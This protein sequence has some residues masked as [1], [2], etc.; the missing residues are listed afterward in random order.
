MNRDFE[1][2]DLDLGA[3]GRFVALASGRGPLLLVL[4]GFPDSPHGM[5]PLVERAAARGFRAVAP[6]LRGYAPSTGEGPFDVDTLAADVLAIAEHLAPGEPFDLVGHDWGAVISYALLSR[7]SERVRA[8]VTLS[9]P[10]PLAFVRDLDAGQLRRSGYMGLFQLRHVAERVVA[11]RDFAFL[12]RL[13]STW[14]PRLDPRVATAA[15]A[16]AKAAITPHFPAAIEYYRALAWPPVAAARRLRETA[17]RRIDTPTLHLTGA[18]DG[19]IAPYVG[20]ARQADFFR[21]P[22]ASETIAS[23][24][25]FLVLERPDEIATCALGWITRFSRDVRKTGS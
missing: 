8:A 1:R 16:H 11:R 19:C 22:F 18:D 15:I 2:L 13:W 4:H 6:F 24:G 9:V 25:H 7:A 20:R 14:S 21:G 5:L 12:D 10:H 17:A 3:R 23:A